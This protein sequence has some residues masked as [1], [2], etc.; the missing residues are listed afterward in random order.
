MPI[1]TPPWKSYQAVD[2]A[3]PFE[4]AIGRLRS[5]MNAEDVKHHSVRR[6]VVVSAVVMIAA[7]D[8]R[9]VARILTMA[10]SETRETL[11]SEQIAYAVMLMIF[12]GKSRQARQM[13]SEYGRAAQTLVTA[14]DTAAAVASARLKSEGIKRLAR[15]STSTDGPLS[16]KQER[17]LFAVPEHLAGRL[18]KMDAQRRFSVVLAVEVDAKGRRKFLLFALPNTPVDQQQVRLS[19]KPTPSSRVGPA[20]CPPAS[21]MVREATHPSRPYPPA[22]GESTTNP[23][24]APSP[25]ALPTTPGSRKHQAK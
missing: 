11:T 15:A 23:H 22:A 5:G 25:K 17:W 4:D 21:P 16:T 1:G 14:G 2:P 12:G 13:A 20:K 8:D 19:A 9:D 6:K 3:L 10:E 7:M 18:A 24:R